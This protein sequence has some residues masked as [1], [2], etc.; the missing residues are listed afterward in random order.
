MLG[1][2]LPIALYP[3]ITRLYSPEN[4]AVLGL[5]MSMVNVLLALSTGSFEF[6]I[7][8]PK[9]EEE[10]INLFSLV[11][12]ISC[13][14]CLLFFLIGLLFKD[15]IL[16]FFN[17]RAISPWILFVPLSVFL[18]SI[19]NSFTYFFN[20]QKKYKLIAI[21]KVNKNWGMS[22]AQLSFGFSG[23]KKI[24]LVSGQLIGD[25]LSTLLLG[26][27]FIRYN[28][29]SFLKQHFSRSLI[30]K[31]VVEYK[32]FPLFTMPTV[33]MNN[34]SSEILTIL[35]AI[36][37]NSGLT[38]AY[39]LT[40]RILSAPMALIGGALSQTFFQ[41][42]TEI[43][44]GGTQ[45]PKPFVL[46]IWMILF[47]IAIVPLTIIF[48]WGEDLFVIIFG[49]DWRQAGKIASIV[50]PMT[51]FTFMSSPTSSSFMVL[52]KQ[53]YN[54]LFGMIELIYR[55]F[56]FYLGYRL[57]DFLLGLK[58]LVLLEILNVF[59]YNALMWKNLKKVSI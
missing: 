34:M 21:N 23:L 1:Q 31:L 9:K 30:R 36:W 45:D 11:V 32:K 29:F 37:F 38:G 44:N 17:N 33:L 46:R 28:H 39:W 51:L 4:L 18:L 55:P 25:T 48:I 57:N 59:A 13:I 14:N 49:E 40:I 27:N 20:R 26:I 41:K 16:D 42:F 53:N 12:I 7:M 24:G 10:S 5:Y 43:I 19:N 3:I 50:A 56:S 58:I 8:L 54:L 2:L 47:S 15:E 52:R 35:T 22:I 6:S